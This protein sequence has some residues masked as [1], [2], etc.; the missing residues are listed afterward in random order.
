[1]I[2][3]AAEH[4]CHRNFICNYVYFIYFTE[5]FFLQQLIDMDVFNWAFKNVTIVFTLVLCFLSP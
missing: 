3:W 4:V 2:S 1:M 5:F